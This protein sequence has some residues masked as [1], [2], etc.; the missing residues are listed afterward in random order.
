VRPRGESETVMF[1]AAA[2]KKAMS[3]GFHAPD[4]MTIPLNVFLYQEITRL[5]I[6]IRRVRETLEHVI[7]AIRGVATMTP[8][9]ND[10]V[11]AIYNGKPPRHWYVDASGQEIAWSVPSLASWMRGLRDR[12]T[13][14][15]DWLFKRRPG[16]FWLT[17]FFN[18]TGFLTAMKQEVTRR[19]RANG[20]QGWSLED[21]RLA[22]EVVVPVA[23]QPLQQPS[24]DGVFIHG[25]CIEGCA[26]D[27]E[28]YCLKNYDTKKLHQELTLEMRAVTS[29]EEKQLFTNTDSVR[30]YT[31]PLY[32]KPRRGTENYICDVK[33]PTKPP[34]APDYWTMR[35]VALLC[36]TEG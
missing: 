20:K 32:T 11:F 25:L 12:N 4:G 28:H 3:E 23:N 17:G 6:T 16:S 13:Q 1:G 7:L 24:E 26:Y 10:A 34:H 19:N 15:N 36:S 14:L 18:P 30:F 33:L 9:L 31:C 2:A 22:A 21:V 8:E 5:N 27:R 29:A 35:G